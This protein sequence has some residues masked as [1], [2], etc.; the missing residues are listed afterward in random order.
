MYNICCVA[1]R[2][3]TN[4]P[5]YIWFSPLHLT[6]HSSCFNRWFRLHVGSSITA[7]SCL[8][9]RVVF[10][11]CTC[12][13]LCDVFVSRV[14]HVSVTM[15]SVISGLYDIGGVLCHFPTL[16]CVISLLSAVS[17][18]YSLLC[19]FPYSLLCHFPTLCSLLCNS[20]VQRHAAYDI[21]L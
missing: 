7:I 15:G 1:S 18:P 2:F 13:I 3:V 17:F 21:A 19:T 9:P 4:G 10:L 12:A 14:C 6:H 8:E 5:W 11:I 20:D 16:C